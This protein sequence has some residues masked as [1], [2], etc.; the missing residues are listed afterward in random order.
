MTRNRRKIRSAGWKNAFAISL[1]LMSNALAQETDRPKIGLVLSGGGARGFAHIGALKMLDS[2][3]IPIDYIVGASMGGIAGA[4]YSIGYNGHDL[5]HLVQKTDW[6]EIFSDIPRRTELPYFVRKETGRY[7]L[8]LGLDGVKPVMPSG[9]IYGQKVSLLFSSLTF[10]YESVTDFNKLPIPYR[11]VAV[12]LVTGNQ[13]ILKSGSLAKA[14]RATMAIPTVFTPIEYGDSLLIDGG[15]SNNLPINV[16]KEM[17]ADIVIAVDVESP[18]KKRK[19][20]NTVLSVL[21]Q[22]IGLLGLEQRRRNE[23]LIDILIRPDLD[24]FTPADFD[25]D[26]IRKIIQRGHTAARAKVG[27]LINLKEKYLLNRMQ[28]PGVLD[29]AYK[30]PKI[31]DLKITGHTALPFSFIYEQ[32]KMKPTDRLDVS[33]LQERF[34]EMKASGFFEKLSYEIVPLSK[35]DVR[36]II[37]VKEKQ[38]PQ[39]FG[40]SIDGN[41]S[42]PFKFIY[43]LLGIKP[44]D[45]LDTEALNSRIMEM[46]GL[47]YFEYIKYEIEP[48]GENR[49]R[50]NLEIK[51]LPSQRMRVGLRYDDFHKLVGVVNVLGVNWLIP[52]LRFE[53]E[54]QF[55]GLVNYNSKIYYP[56]RTITMPVYPLL[57][58]GFKDIPTNIYDGGSGDLIAS[59]KDRSS[60]FGVGA[61]LLF[62]KCF[63]AEI[64]YQHEYM[65]VTPNIAFSDPAMFPTWKHELRKVQASMT[66]DKLDDV[67]L[68][69][70]GFDFRSSYEGSF[71]ELQS[72]LDYTLFATSANIYH[73]LRQR[74][75]TRLFGYWGTT[76]SVPIYK[77][78]NMGRPDTFIGLDYDQLYGTQMGIVRFDYRYQHKKDIFFKLIANMAF[79]MQYDTGPT[80]L[81]PY[82][83]TGYGVGVKL[84]SL[85]GPIEVIFSRGD[86]VFVGERKKQNLVYFVLGYK[87]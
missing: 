45:R 60:H 1:L 30:H 53:E 44:G 66:I 74:H 8:V 82:N 58:F 79:D 47:G 56:T 76:R 73:T 27:Q 33:F 77:F 28:E 57:K 25:D 40:I 59:Y 31:H 12:D 6:N 72:D 55:A 11:C 67:L 29:L 78:L 63:N 24:A 62:K 15:F 52:G 38:K 7:Q 14:M 83:V 54:L 23:K 20:L 4:L 13:V 43:Q 3:Q 42:L 32:L 41:T 64:E 85:V 37:H 17:G 21:E 36:L 35:N 75:T 16:A 68:P 49:V 84:L 10:P 86:K 22:T 9:I 34:A 48:I 19:Q 87:F 39:I 65:N 70:N 51:E 18:L 69:R 2:L 61:G 50:L 5:E 26:Q 71:K 81:Y 46:Y 80:T